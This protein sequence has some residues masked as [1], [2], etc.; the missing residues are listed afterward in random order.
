MFKTLLKYCDDD[1]K[2]IINAVISLLLLTN[3][4]SNSF[5][6]IFSWGSPVVDASIGSIPILQFRNIS[7]STTRHLKSWIIDRIIIECPVK[8]SIF[9]LERLCFF[10]KEQICHHRPQMTVRMRISSVLHWLDDLE[11][12]FFRNTN[13]ERIIW[14]VTIIA[15][16]VRIENIHLLTLIEHVVHFKHLSTH[17][18]IITVHNKRNLI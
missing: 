11:R 17:Q 5:I 18:L 15:D 2:H 8:L 16:E 1:F 13:R 7:N 6:L 14:I 3:M 10:E 4:L 12:I 9:I